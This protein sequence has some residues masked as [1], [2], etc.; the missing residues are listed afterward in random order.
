MQT[1]IGCHFVRQTSLWREIL[2]HLPRR[3]PV[4][5]LYI[6]QYY[7]YCTRMLQSHETTGPQANPKHPIKLCQV[8]ELEESV[9][10][11]THELSA[12]QVPELKGIH[13]QMRGF[14]SLID[15]SCLDYR[16]TTT[17]MTL[18]KEIWEGKLNRD[19]KDEK[20]NENI[21][22]LFKVQVMYLVNG[23]KVQ[24]E[25]FRRSIWLLLT[26]DTLF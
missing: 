26:S 8:L 1:V 10:F 3:E 5:L 6:R 21:F 16:R 24:R 25:Q 15:L 11:W 7:Q 20:S 17:D 12:S 19:C 23:W 22:I 9:C 14:T 18:V 2:W 13:V 4:T